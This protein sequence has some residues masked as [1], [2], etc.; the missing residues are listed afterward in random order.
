MKYVNSISIT[1]ILAYL[2]VLCGGN[3]FHLKVFPCEGFGCLASGIVGVTYLPLT[4]IILSLV[5]SVIF[6]RK[7]GWTFI[8]KTVLSVTIGILL[9]VFSCLLVQKVQTE[10]S[11]AKSKQAEKIFWNQVEANVR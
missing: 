2:L 9:V 4:L 5:A 6:Y 3:V 10:L 8:G 11:I 7:R 1:T